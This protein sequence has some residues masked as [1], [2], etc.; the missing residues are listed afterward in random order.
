VYEIKNQSVYEI[1][2]QSVYEVINQCMKSTES[3]NSTHDSFAFT[4]H[5]K[6]MTPIIFTPG[7]H[8]IR[9]N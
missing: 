2:N 5:Y 7:G 4:S 3:C 8:P 1:K 6:R 9:K